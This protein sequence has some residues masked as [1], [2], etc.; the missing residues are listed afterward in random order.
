MAPPLRITSASNARLKTIRR[1][2]RLRG[3]DTFVVEGYRPLRSAL[4]AGARV[5]ELYVAPELFL[6]ADEPR[7]VAEAGRHGALVFELSGA[8][9]RS[10]AGRPRPDGLAAVVERRACALARL[11]LGSDAFVVVADGIERPGNLGTLARTA[12]AAGA[13]ALVVSHPRIDPFHPDTVQ[14]SVGTLFHLDVVETAA[15]PAI[16]RLRRAGVRVVVATP[17]AKRPFWQADYRGAVTVVVGG[18][19]YGVSAG[20]LKAAD[21]RVAIPMSGAADSLNVAVAAGIVLFEAARQRA[22]G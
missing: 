21:T 13:S 11:R 7:L 1:L 3:V 15:A 5:R 22:A 8:A 10:I 14:G 9:F 18:E 4:E 12:S 19:R 16:D 6:G 2:R 17:D 20:W